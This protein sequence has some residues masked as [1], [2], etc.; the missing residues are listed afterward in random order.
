MLADFLCPRFLSLGRLTEKLPRFFERAERAFFAFV[1]AP[2]TSWSIDPKA[3]CP[4]PTAAS[5]PRIRCRAERATFLLEAEKLV[6][7]ELLGGAD[8]PLFR[9]TRCCF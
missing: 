8:R 2:R 4:S 9:P 1:W 5:A 7:G 6:G 3:R